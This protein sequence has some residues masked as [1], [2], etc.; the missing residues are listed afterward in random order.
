[1]RSKSPQKPP[2]SDAETAEYMRSLAER[3]VEHTRA[4]G[5]FLDWDPAFIHHLDNYCT[6]FAASKPP[7][8]VIHSVIMGAGAYLG[9]MIVRNAAWTW[10]YCTSESAAAV[11]SPDGVRGYPHN[12]VAKRIHNG[13]DHD[14]EAFF[15]YAMTGV[16]PHGTTA[17]VIKPSWWK[18]LRSRS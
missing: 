11:E 15:K 7:P 2:P 10:V 8:E 9:E 17:R 6:Q 18:R 12:K 3:F 4:D 13:T 1:M 14:I 16:V 5:H